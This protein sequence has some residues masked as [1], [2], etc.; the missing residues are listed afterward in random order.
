MSG[1]CALLFSSSLFTGY[2]LLICEL[3]VSRNFSAT[4]LF[5]VWLSPSII[6]YICIPVSTTLQLLGLIEFSASL[7]VLPVASG[8]N[9][10]VSV[11]LRPHTGTQLVIKP[12]QCPQKISTYGN[13]GTINLESQA[14]IYKSLPSI[15][16]VKGKGWHFNGNHCEFYTN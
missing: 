1:F 7:R 13:Y 2:V 16:S 11:S 4:W 9:K 14:G 12:F 10:A 8:Q 3:L 15:A 5:V 6:L